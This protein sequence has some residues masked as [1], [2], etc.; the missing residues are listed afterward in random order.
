MRCGN[1]GYI[2]SFLVGHKKPI[3]LKIISV[4]VLK[5]CETEG[6]KHCK[7]LKIKVFREYPDWSYAPE[8]RWNRKIPAV[9][10]CFSALFRFL[11]FYSFPLTQICC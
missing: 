1:D 6:E 11:D 9:L 3:W 5:T 10:F 4:I 8:N 2:I 7:A